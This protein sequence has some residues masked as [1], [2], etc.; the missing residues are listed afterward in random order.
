MLILMIFSICYRAYAH[1]NGFQHMLILMIFSICYGAYG[2]PASLPRLSAG[3][4]LL[5]PLPDV[6]QL[7]LP[8][9]QLS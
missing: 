2:A 6:W 3:V 8:G 1:L 9:L 4:Q 5:Q 7:R